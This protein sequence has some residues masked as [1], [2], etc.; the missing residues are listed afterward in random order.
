MA[1]Q[2]FAEKVGIAVDE[3]NVVETPKGEYL[4]AEVT[5]KCENAATILEGI[6]PELILGIPFPKACVGAILISALPV[7]LFHSWPFWENSP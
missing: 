7:P 5:E 1:A 4:T 2:K 6:L 3:I